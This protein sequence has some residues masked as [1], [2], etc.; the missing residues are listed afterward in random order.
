M[1]A[2]SSNCSSTSAFLRQRHSRDHRPRA[3][4]HRLPPHLQRAREPRADG[5][6]AARS[7]FGRRRHGARDR[8]RLPRRHGRA[9]RSARRR[10]R[11]PR[12]RPPPT[13]QGG[14]RA[15][16]PGRLPP[17]A[18][19][20]R[21]ARARDGL[22]LLPRPRRRPAPDRRRGR[23][24][25]RARLALRRA[26]A[27]SRTGAPGAASCRAAGSLYAQMLLGHPRPRPDRRLQVLP[28]RGAR[29]DRP[30][31]RLVARLRVPDRDHLPR[32]P[33]GLPRGRDPDRLR[34]PRGRR[35]EDEPRD[36]AR[37]DLAGAGCLR[38]AGARRP[39]E[40]SL[41]HGRAREV[42]DATFAAEVLEADRPVVVDFWAPWCGPCT[43]VGRD[44]RGARR[45]ARRARRASSR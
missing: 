39:S 5:H 16:L 6:R 45:R 10:A 25:P 8:R 9:R 23:R 38:A 3:E 15:R 11:R 12:R 43:A 18:R 14:P 30:R 31:R 40:L 17:R 37:G 33:G 13:G 2:S 22:R 20:R 42:T 32:A 26:A 29:G 7:V 21:R 1:S 34:R 19:R 27:G 4:G 24:R 36:R 41:A 28:A 44:P 35:L